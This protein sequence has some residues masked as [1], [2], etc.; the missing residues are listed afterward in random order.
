ENR[1][2]DSHG[3]GVALTEGA[4]MDRWLVRGALRSVIE[5]AQLLGREDDPLIEE[6]RAALERVKGP[7][8]G[9]DG[10]ILEWHAALPGEEPDRRHVSHLAFGSAACHARKIGRAHV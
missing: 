6:A 8:I 1:W 5:S 3:R 4:G 2:L 9:P 10:G 7:R